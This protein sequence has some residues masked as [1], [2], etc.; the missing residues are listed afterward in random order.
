MKTLNAIFAA[1]LF[2][3]IPFLTAAGQDEP[4]QKDMEIIQ[5]LEDVFAGVLPGFM[6]PHAMGWEGG[7]DIVR[8]D[9]DPDDLPPRMLGRCLWRMPDLKLSKEQLDKIKSLH[10]ELRKKNIPLIS[11]LKLKRIEMK[12]LMDAE[13]PDKD[14][15]TAKIKEIETIRTRI[16]TNRAMT[17]VDVLNVLNK[18]QREKLEELRCAPP[19]KDRPVKRMMKRYRYFDRN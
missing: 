6:P 1:V 8:E 18:D 19:M 9:N 4:S 5:E 16:H 10:N 2:S 7:W 15:I 13:K 17:H 11:D 14:K 12:E 3:F